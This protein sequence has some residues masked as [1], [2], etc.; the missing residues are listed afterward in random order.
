[1]YTQHP[2]SNRKLRHNLRFY[3]ESLTVITSPF[4]LN[5]TVAVS[6]IRCNTSA[7]FVKRAIT[8]VKRFPLTSLFA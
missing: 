6:P 3:L 4:K 2:L 7:T 1:M 5:C 8:P